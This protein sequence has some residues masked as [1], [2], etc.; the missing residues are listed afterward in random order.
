MRLARGEDSARIA[1]RPRAEVFAESIE[2]EYGIETIEPLAFV[3]RAMIAQ[4]TE[5]LQMR[6]LVA[7]YITLAR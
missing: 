7:D 3:M 6:G 1:M 4:L 2:L 5:R